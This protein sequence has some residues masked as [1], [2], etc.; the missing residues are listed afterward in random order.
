[1]ERSNIM[2]IHRAEHIP[3][4]NY[5]K[6]QQHQRRIT[7]KPFNDDKSDY[8]TN[9]KSY[10]DYEARYNSFLSTIVNFVNDIVL[11]IGIYN[12]NSYFLNIVTLDAVG[13]NTTDNTP[14]FESFNNNQMYYVPKG[15]YRTEHLPDG[16]FFGEGIIKYYNEEIPLARHVAQR[17]RVN[18]DKSTKE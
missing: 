5:Y 12:I 1:W 7:Y 13:D 15:T 14:L 3:N 16:Y 4:F 6:G 9:A 17:V 18:L 10:Y 8:N 11:R 2:D